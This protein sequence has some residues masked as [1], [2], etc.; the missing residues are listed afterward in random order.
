MRAGCWIDLLSTDPGIAFEPRDGDKGLTQRRWRVAKILAASGK[1]VSQ[2]ASQQ[3]AKS[4]SK[5]YRKAVER[6]ASK[7]RRR[8]A[9]RKTIIFSIVHKNQ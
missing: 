9:V 1:A 4:P 6:A 7:L 3:T 2:L 5:T 8:R